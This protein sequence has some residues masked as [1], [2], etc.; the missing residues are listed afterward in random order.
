MPADRSSARRV[1][2]VEDDSLIALFLADL[3]NEGG[4][5]VVGPVGH[6]ADA[7]TLA[8]CEPLDAAVLDVDLAG[9]FVWPAAEILFARRIP[10]LLLTGF[11]ACLETPV[12]CQSAPTLGKPTDETAVLA[13]LAGILT[14][15]G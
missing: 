3:L 9:L 10:F 15:T 13:A 5:S 2:L 7:I 1:L 4:Y 14:R 11:G 6:L 12:C 8:Q